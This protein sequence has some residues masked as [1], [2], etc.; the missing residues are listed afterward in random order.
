MTTIFWEISIL[1]EILFLIWF[2][3]QFFLITKFKNIIWFF[4]PKVKFFS[5]FLFFFFFFQQF[6]NELASN[7]LQQLLQLKSSYAQFWNS[8]VF[9]GGYSQPPI[10]FDSVEH[11]LEQAAE[12]V[13]RLR[14]YFSCLRGGKQVKVGCIDGTAHEF[15]WTLSE[16]NVQH[17]STNPKQFV[18]GTKENKNIEIESLKNNTNSNFIFSYLFEL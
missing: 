9:K 5:L 15:F 16:A 17:A 4:F 12:I 10:S 13:I 14:N 11:L 2:C 8:S 6:T 1:F 7:Q 18:K 3:F